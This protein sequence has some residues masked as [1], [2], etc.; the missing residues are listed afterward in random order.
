MAKNS[1]KACQ[2]NLITKYIKVDKTDTETL[3]DQLFQAPKDDVETFAQDISEAVSS[4]APDLEMPMAS[5]SRVEVSNPNSSSVEL[6]EPLLKTS[7]RRK[8]SVKHVNSEEE[9][10]GR[11]TS[12]EFEFIIKSLEKSEDLT[13]EEKQSQIALLK[14]RRAKIRNR[15]HANASKQKVKTYISKL[16]S[17]IISLKNENT[18]LHA[19]NKILAVNETRLTCTSP[20]SDC[21]EHKSDDSN[22]TE[23]EFNLDLDFGENDTQRSQNSF[24][25]TRCSISP[26][27]NEFGVLVL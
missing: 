11:C 4:F 18:R 17:Q 1:K 22:S 20:V 6:S 25:Q 24:E 23:I 2:K 14:K 9:T 19:L 16:E 12:K 13:K 7:K 5:E 15:H 3:F 21:D 10:L 26:I 27:N 8:S